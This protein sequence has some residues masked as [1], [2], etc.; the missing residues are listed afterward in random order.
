MTY[1]PNFG[2]PYTN[3]NPETSLGYSNASKNCNKY[4]FRSNLESIK[5]VIKSKALWVRL[6]LCYKMRGKNSDK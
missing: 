6:S 1:R 2:N 3:Y 5:M 4:S